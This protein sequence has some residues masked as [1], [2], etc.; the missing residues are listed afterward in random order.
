MASGKS[1]GDHLIEVLR[2]LLPVP[3]RRAM[4][5]SYRGL[6]EILERSTPTYRNSVRKMAGLENRHRGQRCFLIGNGPSLRN[7]DLSLL[8]NEITFGMNRIYLAFDDMGFETTYYVAVNELVMEQF[9]RDI[10]A[11]CIPKILYWPGRKWIPM[12]EHTMFVRFG[13]PQTLFEP[14]IRKRLGPGATVTYIAMQIAFF[15]GFSQVI[16]IGVDH[17]FQTQGDPHKQ[18]VSE[19]EDPN[20]FD[21][22]YFGKGVKWQLP[23]LDTSEM[24]YRVARGRFESAGREIVDATV[25]GKLDVFRKVE[26]TSLFVQ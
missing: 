2:Q 1:S 21:P 16:L 11:L 13:A 15:M 9:A 26:Y 19:G 8:R 5:R 25:G 14:D 7:T 24:A 10:S 12:D 18:V 3:V 20:H 17:S 22:R 6:Q 4:V 23:D